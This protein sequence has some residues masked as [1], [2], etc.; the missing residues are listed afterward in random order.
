MTVLAAQETSLLL[1]QDGGE[2]WIG[3][4]DTMESISAIA[5]SETYKQDT[6]M[7][8]GT[9]GGQVLISNDRGKSWEATALFDGEAVLAL[10]VCTT[11]DQCFSYAV[12]ALQTETGAWELALRGGMDWQTVAT[13]QS[14]EPVAVIAFKGGDRLFCTLGRHTLYVKG[15]QLLSE[16]ELE[17]SGPVSCLA[18]MEE[19]LLAGTRF[20]LCRSIDDGSSWK[21]LTTDISAVALYAASANRAYAVSM[22]GMLWQIDFA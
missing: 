11:G 15:N 5:L 18:P 10:A 9:S 2:Q 8:V 16:G 21:V 7:L 19:G 20:G 1:S 14:D 22:G 17:V 12:T 4:F 6:T 13:R 3:L